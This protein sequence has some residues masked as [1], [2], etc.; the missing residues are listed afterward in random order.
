[1]L[2]RAIFSCCRKPPKTTNST[3][4]AQRAKAELEIDQKVPT[5]KSFKTTHKKTQRNTCKLQKALT[6]TFNE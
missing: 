6:K 3:D 5:N 1:M 2:P 4:I